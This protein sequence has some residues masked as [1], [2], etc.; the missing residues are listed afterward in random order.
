MTAI[1][2]VVEDENIGG[3]S[4]FDSAHDRQ[5]TISSRSRQFILGQAASKVPLRH[6]SSVKS[7]SRPVVSEQS[8]NGRPGPETDYGTTNL[9]VL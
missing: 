8:V 9:S 5:T 1:S 4:E 6:V 3:V 2:T 7:E